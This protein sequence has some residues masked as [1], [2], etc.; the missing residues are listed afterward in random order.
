MNRMVYGRI[1]LLPQPVSRIALGT[2]SAP[3]MAGENT[4]ALL[5]GAAERGVNAFDCARSYGRAEEVL[6]EWIRRRKNRD[7]VIVIS[8]G[9]AFKN[10]SDIVK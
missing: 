6:G 5:D 3:M 2:A 4:D 8:A 9:H 1:E 7:R 10:L